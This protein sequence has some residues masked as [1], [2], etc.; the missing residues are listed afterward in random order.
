VQPK[1]KA[2]FKDGL[3]EDEIVVPFTPMPRKRKADAVGT[4]SAPIGKRLG[5][6]SGSAT[7]TS[8]PNGMVRNT[9]H[10]RSH[11]FPG[12]LPASVEEERARLIDHSSA[13][14]PLRSYGAEGPP[15]LSS[16]APVADVSQLMYLNNA[17]RKLER[18]QEASD[19]RADLYKERY[20]NLLA[21]QN[22]TL[23]RRIHKDED[24][25]NALRD[26]YQRNSA[27]QADLEANQ[28]LKMQQLR[29][30]MQQ[31]IS[32]MENKFSDLRADFEIV[33]RAKERAQ[34]S[35]SSPTSTH[36]VLAADSIRLIVSTT[37]A[38][39]SWI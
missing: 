1:K 33:T 32:R 9:D 6:D 17:I 35:I 34:A 20:E 24:Q 18:K 16:V 19:K 38:Y 22:K 31:Q 14:K 29:E 12:K 26:Q 36:I 15:N 25:L 37:C 30:D 4:L 5:A 27:R 13:D 39:H 8:S 21:K 10:K 2:R 23:E 11:G 3:S 28:R 7:S